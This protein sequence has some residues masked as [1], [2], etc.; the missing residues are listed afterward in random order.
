MNPLVELAHDL[1]DVCFDLVIQGDHHVEAILLYPETLELVLGGKTRVGMYSR[2]EVF[3]R[4][5]ASLEQDGVGC[6]LEE[7]YAEL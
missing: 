6:K 4:V 1:L 2:S 3:G 7:L 5:N